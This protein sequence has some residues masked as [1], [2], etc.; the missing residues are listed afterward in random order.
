MF[1]RINLLLQKQKMTI[2]TYTDFLFTLA[3]QVSETGVKVI[4]PAKTEKAEIEAVLCKK[5]PWILQPHNPLFE[6]WLKY[7]S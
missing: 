1:S 4:A 2:N 6:F 7:F 3:I 5:A